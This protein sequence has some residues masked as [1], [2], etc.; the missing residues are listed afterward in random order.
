[1]RILFFSLKDKT[2]AQMPVHQSQRESKTV[3]FQTHA[4]MKKHHHTIA[5]RIKMAVRLH[6]KWNLKNM[7]SIIKIPFYQLMLHVLLTISATMCRKANQL[8]TWR[9]Q[10]RLHQTEDQKKQRPSCVP[11]TLKFLY[12]KHTLPHFTSQKLKHATN[13]RF[14]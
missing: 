6:Y 9:H 7:R 11:V 3:S 13:K 8:N 4:H 5:L 2:Q 1:M 12:E 10:H 14:I